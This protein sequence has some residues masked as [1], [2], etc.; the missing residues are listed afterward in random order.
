MITFA[1]FGTLCNVDP[2]GIGGL[3]R[4]IKFDPAS[5]SNI[6]LLIALLIS[7]VGDC[8]YETAKLDD[9]VAI[10]DHQNSTDFPEFEGMH[11]FNSFLYSLCFQTPKDSSLWSG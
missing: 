2:L 11:W 4:L 10:P 7:A 3:T 5:L 9:V 1:A 8:L 6:T